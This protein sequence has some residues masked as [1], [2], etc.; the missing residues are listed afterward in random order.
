MER[1]YLDHNATTPTH[2]E[3]VEA[4]ANCYAQGYANP[5]SPHRPGQQ[6]RRLLEDAR[7]TIAEILGA[8]LSPPAPRSADLHQ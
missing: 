2:P 4:M 5:A 8:D 3:V 6:A 7:E 1:I